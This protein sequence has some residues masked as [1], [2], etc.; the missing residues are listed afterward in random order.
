MQPIANKLCEI[1]RRAYAHGLVSGTEGNFSARLDDG[2]MLCTPTSLCKGLLTPGDLCVIDLSGRQFGGRQERSSEVLL[3]LAIYEVDARIQAVIHTHPPFATTF[4]VLGE[5]IPGGI[6]PE[7]EV[8]LGPV[9]LVRYET[10]GTPEIA[11]AMKPYVR[12]QVAAILQ[13]HGTV[14]WGRDLETAYVLTE[15]LEAV[16]RA[17][18]QARLIGQPRPIPAEKLSE[19]TAIRERLRT[20]D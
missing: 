12:D 11:T 6:L 13:N 7:G 20:T 10:P 15:T 17:V 2:R 8:F 16:C 4:S 14:T 18:Y 5:S 3:H 9:P 19:L 1:G